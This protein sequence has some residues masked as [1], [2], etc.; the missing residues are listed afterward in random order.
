MARPVGVAVLAR[1]A[2]SGSDVL[3]GPMSRQV[4]GEEAG[5]ESWIAIAARDFFSTMANPI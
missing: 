1:L 4:W 5:P 3:R 2:G